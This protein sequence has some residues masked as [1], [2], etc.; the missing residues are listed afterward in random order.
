MTETPNRAFPFQV[1]QAVRD[2]ED[3]QPPIARVASED[4]QAL[5]WMLLGAE[6]AT[7]AHDKRVSH[8]YDLTQARMAELGVR[9]HEG[10][11]GPL[12]HR[13]RLA[14]ALD[15]C[16]VGKSPR[17]RTGDRCGPTD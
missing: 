17:R 2:G 12:A 14:N 6:I 1:L 3:F 8:A 9:D 15:H 4:L 10:P 11:E 16:Y 7:G 5:S 13:T